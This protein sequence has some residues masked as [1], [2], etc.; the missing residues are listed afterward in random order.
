MHKYLA[1]L[2]VTKRLVFKLFYIIL[3][4]VNHN[5]G[6]SF[7]HNFRLQKPQSAQ[8]RLLYSD[9]FPLL[10]H[11]F[12]FEKYIITNKVSLKLSHIIKTH[13]Y[14]RRIQRSK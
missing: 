12:E 1:D 14:L 6:V 10:L 9:Y 13:Y 5:G 8:K 11:D 2:E 4:K 7:E 3:L